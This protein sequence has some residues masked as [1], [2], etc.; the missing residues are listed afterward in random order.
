MLPEKYSLRSQPRNAGAPKQA[1][2]CYP[3]QL[4]L[5]PSVTTHQSG[6]GGHRPEELETLALSEEEHTRRPESGEEAE[7]LAQGIRHFRYL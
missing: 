1:Y 5:P 3:P 7:T 6:D 2:S 4:T